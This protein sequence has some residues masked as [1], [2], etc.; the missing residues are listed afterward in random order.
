MPGVLPERR[1]QSLCEREDVFRCDEGSFDVDLGE[2]RLPVGAQVLIAEAARDLE[3]AVKSGDHQ[4]LFVH[5]RRLWQ[6]IELARMHP[7]RNDVIA[8][9]RRRRLRENRRFYLEV[10]ALIEEAAGG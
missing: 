5:L 7:A 2:L 6:S 4:Q 9:S 3:V 1:E 8:R 10:A